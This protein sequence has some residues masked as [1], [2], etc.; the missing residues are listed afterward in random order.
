MK[1]VTVYQFC[2]FQLFPFK[3]SICFHCVKFAISMVYIIYLSVPVLKIKT[4]FIN[5][6]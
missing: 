4:I 2:K 6:I 5:V 3:L 1:R